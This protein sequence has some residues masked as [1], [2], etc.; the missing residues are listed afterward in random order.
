MLDRWARAAALAEPDARQAAIWAIREA[1]HASGVVPA[2]VQDLYMA[3]GAGKW[4]DRTVPALNLRGWSYQT[5]RSVFRAAGVAAPRTAFAEVTLTVPGK[6]DKAY[7]GLFTLV[8]NVDAQFFKDRFGSD[9]GLVMKPTR[10][11]GIDFLGDDWDRYKDQYQPQRE[12]TDREATRVIEFAKLINQA[13]DAEFEKRIDSFLD[14]DAFLRFMAANALTSN[15]ESFLALGSNYALHLDAQSDKFTLIP[16]D[17]EFSFANFLLMGSAEQL[18]DL[19]LKKPYPGENRLPDRL[20][21]IKDVDR[22]YEDLLKDLSRTV[23]T[24]A[25]LLKDAQAISQATAV[26]PSPTNG[27]IAS[28]IRDSPCSRRHCSGRRDGNVAGCG[29]SRSRR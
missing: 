28:S 27:S 12:A 1:A 15:L 22:K 29:R 5:C 23:V 11:R 14:V 17:L 21:A 13:T 7:L 3:R 6:H 9:L 20:L 16:G 8:E 10:M 2:S 24:K 26:L 25:Q 19:S 18:L 4:S